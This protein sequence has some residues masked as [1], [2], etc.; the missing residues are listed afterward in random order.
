M[1]F[2]IP[3]IHNAILTAAV[4]GRIQP[5]PIRYESKYNTIRYRRGNNRGVTNRR[6]RRGNRPR[7]LRARVA[8]NE[9]ETRADGSVGI[10]GFGKTSWAHSVFA[11]HSFTMN[12]IAKSNWY[13]FWEVGEHFV[14]RFDESNKHVAALCRQRFSPAQG[15]TIGYVGRSPGRQIGKNLLG[16]GGVDE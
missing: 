9:M 12:W 3:F 5:I 11:S 7:I 4:H 6:N 14:F 13:T 2:R 16:S 10:V 1:Y 8:L 15:W